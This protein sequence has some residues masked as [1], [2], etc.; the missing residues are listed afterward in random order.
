MT[1]KESQ[2]IRRWCKY[3]SPDGSKKFIDITMRYYQGLSENEAKEM[4]KEFKDYNFQV[5]SGI[6]EPGP[7]EIQIPKL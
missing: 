6:I 1:N 3:R 4:L 5:I 2:I 7:I